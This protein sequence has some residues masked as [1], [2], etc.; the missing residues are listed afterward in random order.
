MTNYQL[1]GNR[2]KNFLLLG[3]IML[4]I[5]GCELSPKNAEKESP[6]QVKSSKILVNT[7]SLSFEL[8][9]SSFHIDLYMLIDSA[10]RDSIPKSWL[11][12]RNGNTRRDSLPLFTGSGM[13][14][15]INVVKDE[16]SSC[17][18]ILALDSNTFVFSLKSWESWITYAVRIENNRCT[19]PSY[20]STLGNGAFRNG[21]YYS[22]YS[23]IYD[24]SRKNLIFP[25]RQ[26][27][28][29]EI[30]TVVIM[31]FNNA[32]TERGGWDLEDS[33]MEELNLTGDC[34]APIYSSIAKLCK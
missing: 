18:K 1:P 31:Y 4:F 34:G 19:F 5:C 16:E 9:N 26:R 14:D 20:K 15:T 29:K 33:V 8:N 11:I 2:L 25:L 23:P 30:N 3:M 7:D 27:S 32:F 10:H 22:E 12:L 24:V 6:P 17:Q 13:F 28:S 21:Y